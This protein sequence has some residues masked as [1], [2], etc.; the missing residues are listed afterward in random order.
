MTNNTDIILRLKFP[1]YK[2]MTPVAPA[3]TIKA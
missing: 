2:H 3:E 1:R